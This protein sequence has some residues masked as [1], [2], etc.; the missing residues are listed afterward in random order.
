MIMGQI[1]V[2]IC[3]CGPNIKD[4]IDI[5]KVIEEVSATEDV[6]AI[7]R[8]PLLC[9]NDG[10]AFLEEEI[11]KE[12]LTHLVVAACSPKDHEQTFMGVCVRAGINPYLLQMINIREQCAWTTSDPGEATDKAIKAVRAGIARVG[13]HDPLESKEIEISPDVLVIGG[14]PAGIEAA[15]SL[16]GKNRNVTL[17]EK[18]EVLGGKARNIARLLPH[19]GTDP[20]LVTG[21][22]AALEDHPSVQILL[23]S[24]VT[25]V[26]GF[27]GNFEITVSSDNGASSTAVKAGAIVVATGFELYDIGRVEP[28]GKSG[29]KNVL[30]A[31]EFEAM[32]R[33]GEIVLE[34]GDKPKS[35]ALVHCIGRKECGYCSKTCCLHLLRAAHALKDR[36]PET[37]VLE[38]FSDLCLPHKDD[39]EFYESAKKKG[40]R[41]IRT[42][43]EPKF[44]D[45]TNQWEITYSSAGETKTQAVDMLVLAP[46]TM[47]AASTPN[48]AE[49]L[50]IPLD[51]KGFFKPA[52]ELLDPVATP[53]E[54]IYIAGCSSG[55]KN[56]PESLVQ[57]QAA[58][59][60]IF[61]G[62]IPGRTLKTEARVC[63]V[64][65]EFC[66]GCQTCLTVCF[67]GAIR[68][69]EFKGVSVVNEA[70]CRGCGSC[71]GSCPSGAIRAKHFT[72]DQIIREVV[73][74]LR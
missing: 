70:I 4:R 27:L 56:I 54:G 22:I 12:G 8:F 16:A 68:F 43:S 50:N 20:D 72:D 19:Q 55:P 59:G 11:K 30:T 13:L 28:F 5:D 17:V 37:E 60:K 65:E 2:Y 9:S 62:L 74:A 63:M 25:D 41:F 40:I 33:S 69:D 14:G 15:L 7:K 3:E 44:K 18:D 52:H 64:R 24:E 35:V 67:Y 42:D 23:S 6:H 10:K 29:T 1:G 57:A 36:L 51:E 61:A 31:L 21:K 38:F 73:E 39:Q 47:P 58:A 66:T 26:R 34:N 46:A 49:K 48:L 53:G 32:M 45:K 71:V